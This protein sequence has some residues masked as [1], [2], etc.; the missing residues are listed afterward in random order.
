MNELNNIRI[1]SDTAFVPEPLYAKKT[2]AW[3]VGRSVK[4]G[5][6]SHEGE[7][8]Y[9]VCNDVTCLPPVGIPFRIEVPTDHSKP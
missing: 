6:Q 9:M 7:V 3:Y 1:V 2:L 5:F 8:E 4:I